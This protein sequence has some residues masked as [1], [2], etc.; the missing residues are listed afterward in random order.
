MGNAVKGY[1]LLTGPAGSSVIVQ[2]K[3]PDGQINVAE[4]V[5]DHSSVKREWTSSYKRREIVEWEKL[6]DGIVYISLNNFGDQKVVTKFEELLPELYSATGIIMDLRFNGG[7]GDD[8]VKAILKYFTDKPYQQFKVKTR[9]HR[10]A[11]KAWG[12]FSPDDE[13]VGPYYKGNAWY[14]FPIS[15]VE[16]TEGDKIKAPLVILVSNYTGSA[17]EDLLIFVD[18]WEQVT[19]VGQPSFGSTGQPIIIDLPGGGTA[20][21]CSLR[22]TYPDGREFVGFGV[23]PD[24]FVEPTVSSLLDGSDPVLEKGIKTLKAKISNNRQKLFREER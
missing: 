1:G 22:C 19:T 4:L 16:P 15:I 7:G 2:A 11:H 14:E 12:K 13:E 23:Q 24:I 17:A 6:D 18:K 9:E 21:V 10:G 20:R 8:K 3:T 5:R